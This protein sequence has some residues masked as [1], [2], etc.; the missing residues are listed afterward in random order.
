MDTWTENAA[1][2]F[3]CG[4]RIRTLCVSMTPSPHPSTSS[5]RP[6]NPVTSL[7]NNNNGKLHACVRAAEDI[8]PIKVTRAKYSVPLPTC[9]VKKDYGQPINH[10]RLLLVVFG[11]FFYC[12]SV[13]NAQALSACSVP[14]SLFLVNFKCHLWAWNTNYSVLNR[15]Q[16]I[17]SDANIL[18]KMLRKTGEKDCIGMCGHGLRLSHQQSSPTLETCWK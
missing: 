17:R 3:S 2:A 1:L 10:F 13:Y 7:N 8:E 18:E 9:W 4:Q 12:L 16:W 15:L 5:L 14:S 6:L 11:F